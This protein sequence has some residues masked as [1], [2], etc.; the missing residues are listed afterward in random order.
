[1]KTALTAPQPRRRATL[2][3]AGTVDKAERAA[4]A[5]QVGNR[6]PPMNADAHPES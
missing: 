2:A 5:A 4:E 1:M 3:L 6:P